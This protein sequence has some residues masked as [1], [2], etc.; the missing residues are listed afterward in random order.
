MSER[1]PTLTNKTLSQIHGDLDVS[2]RCVIELGGGHL[3]LEQDSS[4]GAPQIV[5]GDC[6]PR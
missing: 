6:A 1:T 3:L 2:V 4:G 5:A